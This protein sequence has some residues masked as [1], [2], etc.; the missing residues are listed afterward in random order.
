MVDSIVMIVD[1][2]PI[3]KNSA[4]E[5]IRQG[6]GFVA[7]GEMLDCKVIFMGDAVHM[8]NKNA[9]PTA[10]GIDPADEALEMAEL[11]D[12]EIYVLDDSLAEAGM[13]KDDLVEYE[14]LQ[15]ATKEQVGDWIVEAD[16]A[17]RY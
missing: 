10:V 13:S 5:A 3:G 6:A 17:F 2:A 11:S 7:L 14:L 9:D 4:L 1:S 12:L 16:M 15:V 8:L